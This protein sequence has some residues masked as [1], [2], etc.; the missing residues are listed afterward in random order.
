M[1][2]RTLGNSGTIVSS[3]ALGTM[4]F[5][6]MTSQD[7]SFNVLDA[8]V[9]AGGTL[10]DTADVY[11]GGASEETLGK[12]FA[13]RAA[14]TTEP[15]VLATKG[16]SPAGDGTNDQGNSRRHLDRQLNQSLRRL[17]RENVDL[18]QLHAWDP[19]TPVEETIAFLGD[20]ISSGKIHSYGISNFTG[21]QL[22]LMVSTAKAMNVAPPVTLQ[23]QY[24]LLSRES[25]SDVFLGA[26]YNHVGILAW[27]PL[28][29]G[30]LTGKYSRHDNPS[31]ATRAGSDN[32]IYQ[33]TA[34]YRASDPHTWDIVDAVVKAADEVGAS[35]ARVALSWLHDRPGMVAPIIGARNV[36]QL[37]D[38]LAAADLHLDDAVRDRLNAVSTPRVGQYPYG[39]FGA[40]QRARTVEGGTPL[41]KVI[42][43]AN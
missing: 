35:A 17:G 37:R 20:A 21:W 14:D 12:W 30:F 38:N 13:S 23:Q 3:M 1:Q 43:E 4:D 39:P 25:E 29:D 19:L 9:E 26:E 22:Q 18:Y 2:N 40:A 24:S 28:A 10:I 41:A 42:A 34:G 5:G 15:V 8:F 6:T 16:R 7:D 31:S 27:S 32:P 36:D 33:F 11:G